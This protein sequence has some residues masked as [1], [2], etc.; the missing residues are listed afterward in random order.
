MLTSRSVK[1]RW[2]AGLAAWLLVLVLPMAPASGAEAQGRVTPV[3]RAYRKVQNAVVNISTTKVVRSR[4]GFFGPD[5][6]DDVFPSP[7]VRGVP[8][9]SLGSGFVIHPDGYIITNDHVVRRAK[10]I[11]VTTPDNSQYTARVISSDSRF[12][13]AVLKV[14]PPDGAKLPH[15]PLGRSDDLMVGE[16]VIAIGNPLGYA[17]TLTTGVIS[18]LGR[19]MEF[20]GGVKYTDIVQTDA[21]INPG[22][23]GG[24]LLNIHGE[25]I[26]IN[27]AIRADAQNIGFAIPV[28]ALARELSALLDFER[29][30]RVVFGA[31]VAPRHT[32][33]GDEV[34]VTRVRPGTP[35]EGKLRE[36]D[37]I[38]SIDGA[39]V[40]QISDFMCIMVAREAGAQVELGC[41]REGEDVSATVVL[42]SKPRPDGKALGQRLFGMT[43][44]P[45]TPRLARD[46]RLPVSRG[47]LVVG[48]DESGP[49]AEIGVQ[50][51]DV[52]FQ[53]GAYYVAKLDELGVIL[54]DVRP[55][56]E[57]RIGIVR[58]WVRAWAPIRARGK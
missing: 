54:E 55:G 46:L 12:D 20:S 37:R 16:T 9:Q 10:E 17:S 13:L 52:L 38:V 6:F 41:L 1:W 36:G 56:D 21:P 30:N 47:L 29:L 26:G 2:G 50:L 58:G 39:P 42:E 15:L 23:S 57:V 32:E 14:D 49:A 34:V 18:A 5:R 19:T 53:V 48:L 35:S 51:K 43:L 8:V 31:S 44:R 24:P 33:E 25:L 28:D 40:R 7:L 4:M 27:T 22:N 45:V 3:V 11:T